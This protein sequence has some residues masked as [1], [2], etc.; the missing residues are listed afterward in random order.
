MIEPK[1]I[2][3]AYPFILS[4]MNNPADVLLKPNLSSITKVL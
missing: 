2:N 4:E 1:T 3:N